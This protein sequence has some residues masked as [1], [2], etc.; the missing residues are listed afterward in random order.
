MRRLF[1]VTLLGCLCHAAALLCS[2]QDAAL[3][4]SKFEP[5][6]EAPSSLWRE[7]THPTPWL[8]WGFD[9][10]SRWELVDH[11]LTLQ[12]GPTSELS[13]LRFR[14][15]I[16]A[17]AEPITNLLLHARLMTEPRYF[18]KP[19]SIEG[20]GNE[21][22]LLDQLFIEWSKIGGLPL[23]I[24]AGRQEM[25]FGT[26]WLIYDGTVRDGSRTEFFDA[27]RLT[28]EAPEKKSTIDLIG[29]LVRAEAHDVLP[30]INDLGEHL[31]EQDERAGALYAT[32]EVSRQA[33]LEAY[34]IFRHLSRHL[35]E[36]SDGNLHT[37]GLRVSGR[38]GDRW[39]YSIE[40]AVQRGEVDER[41]VLAYGWN[42]ELG[43]RL[44]GA[45]K[46]RVY[47]GHE[48]LSGD[49]PGTGRHEGWDPM[50]SRRGRFSELMVFT[51]AAEANGRRGYF[52]NLQR[53][54]LGW[55]AN[56][57]RKL[58]LRLEYS[59]M[60]ANSNPMA[61]SEMFSDD[62]RFR[63]HF[64]LGSLRYTATKHVA[65]VL[66]NELFLPG[67]YYASNHRDVAD[68]LRAEVNLTF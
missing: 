48:Y 68:F 2:A 38:I 62:G 29:I 54:S 6:K 5:P 26:R 1:I 61:G 46:H 30:I 19:D 16:W 58:D 52:T 47:V 32:H 33:R 44:G 66:R 49:D 65:F 40:G 34:Y 8:R 3:N 35:P 23:R 55:G 53:P 11:G 27:V 7:I 45:W 41:D 60:L 10:R 50:W 57:T 17:Q 14:N 56:P 24:K 51:Y 39:D 22:A 37:P 18:F 9:S 28:A 42:S 13:Y 64:I 63:G 20:W 15:R 4:A 25:Q 36:G 31:A 43:L 59:P 12:E 21:E 67:N